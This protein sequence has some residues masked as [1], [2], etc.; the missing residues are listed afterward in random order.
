M[1]IRQVLP[2]HQSTQLALLL[3]LLVN[4]GQAACAQNYSSP[5]GTTGATSDNGGVGFL[6]E[7]GDLFMEEV[8]DNKPKTPLKQAPRVPIDLSRVGVSVDPHGN[9][10]PLKDSPTDS[11]A[12]TGVKPFRNEI[13]NTFEALPVYPAYPYGWPYGWNPYNSPFSPAFNPAFSPAFNPA[14]NP[15]FPYQPGFPYGPGP[16]AQPMGYLNLPGYAGYP[17]Y[18]GYP[19]LA[20]YYPGNTYGSYGPYGPYGPFMQPALSLRIGKF[21]AALGS[22]TPPGIPPYFSYPAPAYLGNSTYTQSSMWR[23]FNLAF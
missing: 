16:F 20:G 21:Q 7:K 17:N 1:K 15:A 6:D 9:I 22:V 23:A 13:S 10:V 8:T 19:G 12:G 3:F 18:A 11:W 14:F 5:G 2:L 4:T